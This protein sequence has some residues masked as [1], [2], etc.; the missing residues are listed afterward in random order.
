MCVKFAKSAWCRRSF[1]KLGVVYL[2]KIFPLHIGV[3][4]FIF[5]F[6]TFATKPVLNQ[7]HQTHTNLNYFCRDTF[8]ILLPSVSSTSNDLFLGAFLKKKYVFLLLSIRVT[9]RAHFT[10]FDLI[11]LMPFAKD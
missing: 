6:T 8:H 4:K 9:H 2:V 7:M 5:L 11:I 1:K 10:L 3:Q